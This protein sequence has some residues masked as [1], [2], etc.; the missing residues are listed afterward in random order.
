MRSS[1]LPH[2]VYGDSSSGDVCRIG[3]AV[4][5]VALELGIVE[6]YLHFVYSK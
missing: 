6:A 1:I 2:G 4:T 5:K 3:V